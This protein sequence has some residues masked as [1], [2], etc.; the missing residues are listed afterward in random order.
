MAVAISRR[1][2]K[3]H[4]F[5]IAKKTVTVLLWKVAKIKELHELCPLRHKKNERPFARICAFLNS[6]LENCIRVQAAES[7]HYF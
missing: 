3:M 7:V 2:F 6:I 1:H 4:F 5:G